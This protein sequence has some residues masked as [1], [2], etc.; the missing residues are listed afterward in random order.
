MEN[1]FR[2]VEK[3]ARRVFVLAIVI[4]LMVLTCVKYI[5]STK[6]SAQQA[7]DET[8]AV[9]HRQG[10]LVYKYTKEQFA[11][12]RYRGPAECQCR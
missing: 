1:Q 7:C 6:P 4:T 12:D 5:I 11:G 10:E 2:E 3:P 9:Y 8:C